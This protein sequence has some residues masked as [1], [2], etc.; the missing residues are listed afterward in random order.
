MPSLRAIVDENWI[1]LGRPIL[2]PRGH[3]AG[4]RRIALS[5]FV[6]SDKQSCRIIDLFADA[7]VRR[8][9]MESMEIVRIGD[10]PVFLPPFAGIAEIVRSAAY[11]GSE[12]GTGLRGT[13]LAFASWLR[14]R[15][16]LSSNRRRSQAVQAW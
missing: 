9:R 15:A 11:R 8:I 13:G 5:V 12:P 2:E 3:L 4:V 16:S 10:G 14:Q 1:R 6:T 7:M